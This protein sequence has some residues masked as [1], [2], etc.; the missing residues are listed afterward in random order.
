MRHVGPGLHRPHG[1]QLRSVGDHRRR[2]VR[3]PMRGFHLEH[4]DRL[5][6]RGSG[7]G[8]RV[9]RHRCGVC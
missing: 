8:A 1:L 7:V 9:G 5:L 6:A 4:F 3:F 2:L